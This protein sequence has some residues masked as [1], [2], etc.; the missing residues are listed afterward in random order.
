MLCTQLQCLMFG[1]EDEDA[2]T[3]MPKLCCSVTLKIKIRVWMIS[4]VAFR[5][6]IC[7][8]FNL[9]AYLIVHFSFGHNLGCFTLSGCPA[10]FSWAVCFQTDL[11]SLCQRLS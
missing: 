11:T 6:L 7:F 2:G 10:C 8:N 1:P 3:H 4:N 5:Q 9:M